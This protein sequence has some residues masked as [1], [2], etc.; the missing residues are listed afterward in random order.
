MSGI[1]RIR[2]HDALLLVVVAIV[3]LGALVTAG[4]ASA[5]SGSV[6]VTVTQK[7]ITI[8]GSRSAAAQVVQI[9]YDPKRCAAYGTES[10]RNVQFSDFRSTKP[11]SFKDTIF[12]STLHLAK[13]KPRYVCAYLL[14]LTGASI[15]SVASA[16]AKLS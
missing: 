8:S 5:A 1:R 3:L 16:S 6:H 2:R 9:T 13:P 15:R 14:D 4:L 10:R 7:A 12:R 11:G